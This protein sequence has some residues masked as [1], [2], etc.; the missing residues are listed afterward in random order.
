MVKAGSCCSSSAAQTALAAQNPDSAV[1]QNKTED[2]G[3]TISSHFIEQTIPG[4][5]LSLLSF[6]ASR[7]RRIEVHQRHTAVSC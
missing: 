6:G 7:S 1:R 3:T 4:C 5:P 2:L